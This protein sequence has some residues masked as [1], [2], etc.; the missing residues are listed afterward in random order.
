[1]RERVALLGGSLSAGP[2]PAGGFVVSA[3]LPLGEAG[4]PLGETA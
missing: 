3:V 2:T 4:L 1:M